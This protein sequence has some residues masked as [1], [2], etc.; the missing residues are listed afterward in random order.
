[1]SAECNNLDIS[2]NTKLWAVNC[3]GNGLTNLDVG[4]NTELYLLNCAEN[5][6]TSLDVSQNIILRTLMCDSTVTVTG[7]SDHLEIRQ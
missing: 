6:L 4:Q 7:K 3:A 1:M 2:Q 5:G